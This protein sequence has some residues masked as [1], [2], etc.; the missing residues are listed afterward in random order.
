MVKIIG[1][2]VD[3]LIFIFSIAPKPALMPNLIPPPSKA[4]PA[5]QEV[6][7]GPFLVADDNLTVRSYVDEECDLI[8]LKNA[9]AQNPCH[10]VSANVGGYTR[11][12]VGEDVVLDIQADVD[13]PDRGDKV[14][15]RCVG[16]HHNIFGVEAEDQMRHGS[17]TREHEM[18]YHLHF[19]AAHLQQ[20]PD[21]AVDRGDDHFLE[22]FQSP[23]FW[24]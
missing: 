10:D 20:L 12:D 9:G 3:G 21:D 6:H 14:G 22:P 15:G 2:Y 13:C 5:E 19:N 1:S 18:G 24:A 23:E 16:T 8:T 7:V 4:G 11:K 17:I